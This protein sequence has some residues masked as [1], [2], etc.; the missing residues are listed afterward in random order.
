[1]GPSLDDLQAA[2][3]KKPA[4]GPSV[5]GGGG[6]EELAL[7]RR[8]LEEAQS[9]EWTAVRDQESS[10]PAREEW[11]TALPEGSRQDAMQYFRGGKTQFAANGSHGK[12]TD[13]SWMAAP[14]E[15]KQ[16]TAEEKD[17]KEREEAARRVQLAKAEAIRVSVNEY[18]SQGDRSKSL[19]EL[20]FEE[21]GDDK[22]GKKKKKK[23]KKK[24]EKDDKKSKK[25]KKKKKKRKV[26]ETAMLGGMEVGGW[27]RNQHMASS[28][29]TEQ[30]MAAL[31][32]SAQLRGRFATG[33]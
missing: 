31:S 26:A 15:V 24:K 18:N 29:T 32:N 19:V 30:K 6:E 20:H 17:K 33:L 3:V 25:K 9:R 27:D 23:K 12:D 2:P 8:R 4:V 1:M 16:V 21:G 11:M 28:I 22:D 14:G 13:A 10:G 7:R 5:G